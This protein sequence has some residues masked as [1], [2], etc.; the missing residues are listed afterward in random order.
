MEGQL[1][2]RGYVRE[3]AF[4]GGDRV[5]RVDMVLFQVLV[6]HQ[7]SFKY[8]L[9]V[10]SCTEVTP[11]KFQNPPCPPCPPSRIVSNDQ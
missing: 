10:M 11:T 9:Y 2:W 3:R 5:D 1:G 8:F 7:S 6:Q 4:L